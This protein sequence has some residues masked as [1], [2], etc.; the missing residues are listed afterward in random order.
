MRHPGLP[1]PLTIHVP[2]GSA[3]LYRI[4]SGKVFAVV[5][6][7]FFISHPNTIIQTENLDI[8]ALPIA[9]TTNVLLAPGGKIQT[10][11]VLGFHTA[12]DTGISGD[13]VQGQ[14]FL[15]SSWMDAGIFAGTLADVTPLRHK[16]Q[17]CMNN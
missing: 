11:C 2:R 12:F 16:L 14:T 7:A 13:S 10:C 15:W 9:L 6:T 8:S 3:T 17:K 5:D 4:P 1:T